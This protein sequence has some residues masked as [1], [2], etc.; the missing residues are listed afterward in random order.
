MEDMSY[1]CILSD[2]WILEFHKSCHQMMR[3]CHLVIVE[4]GREVP[5]WQMR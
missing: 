4:I 5:A 1:Y 2:M 3:R